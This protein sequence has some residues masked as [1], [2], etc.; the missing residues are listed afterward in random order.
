ML[1]V[2]RA[3]WLSACVDQ[4]YQWRRPPKSKG[5]SE[6][7]QLAL[8]GTY[9]VNAC[10]FSKVVPEI[11]NASEYVEKSFKMF[12]CFWGG[13]RGRFQGPGFQNPDTQIGD[14]MANTIAELTSLLDWVEKCG[15]ACTVAD[16][17]TTLKGFNERLSPLCQLSEFRLTIFVQIMVLSGC[18]K[19]GHGI[20]TKAYPVKE[21]GSHKVLCLRYKINPDHL[22]D[23]M[24]HIGQYMC[25]D[26]R[27]S[28]QPESMACE[29]GTER[30]EI[31]E[32]FMRGQAIYQVGWDEGQNRFLAIRKEYGEHHFKTVL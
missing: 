12:G 29:M 17:R 5:L 10:L 18:V 21:R 8:Y 7:I 9:Q 15:D 16:F 14:E 11:D 28:D 6:L 22:E 4:I 3:L 26:V 32:V 31:Y 30:N 24:Y 2:E 13:P 25:L 20:L 19:G 23:A 27:R 1:G